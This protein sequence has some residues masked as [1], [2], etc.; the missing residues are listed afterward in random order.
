MSKISD[1]T[2]R[3]LVLSVGTHRSSRPLS[4][5]EVAEAI[6]MELERGVRPANLA[7]LLQVD[8]AMLGRFQ[9]LLRLNP[10]IHHLVDWSSRPGTLTFTTASYIAKLPP[11]D[12]PV[13]ANAAIEHGL[14]TKEVEQVVQVAE[15]TSDQIGV[16]V[17]RVLKTRPSVQRVYVFVGAVYS[18]E[19]KGYLA[20]LSQIERDTI[21]RLALDKL[22]PAGVKCHGKLGVNLFTIAGSEDLNAALGGVAEGLESALNRALA[23]EVLAR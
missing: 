14:R 13:L 2:Y 23:H 8:S 20:G 11:T 5:L 1:E 15:R 9:R 22:L 19:V 10:A 6:A 17:E 18:A 7:R 16:C 4:P 12:Q 3:D 21:L